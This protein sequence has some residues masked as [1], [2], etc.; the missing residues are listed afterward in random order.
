[1][2][3]QVFLVWLGFG[4]FYQKACAKRL[5]GSDV[6]TVQVNAQ[7]ADVSYIKVRAESHCGKENAIP[8][9]SMK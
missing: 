8:L 2:S 7:L 4:R 3:S 1:M 5:T 9:F 6:E